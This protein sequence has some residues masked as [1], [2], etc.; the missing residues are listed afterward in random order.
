M[1]IHQQ[2]ARSFVLANYRGVTS[3]MALPKLGK[4]KKAEAAAPNIDVALTRLKAQLTIDQHA[5]DEELVRQPALVQEIGEMYA[6]AL[7]LRD[8]CKA[9]AEEVFASVD[10]ELRKDHVRNKVS[11]TE[12]SI[13]AEIAGSKEYL[14]AWAL[15]LD[16][17]NRADEINATVQAYDS[18]DRAL[19]NLVKLYVAGY[20]STAS[21]R[22]EIGKEVQADAAREAMREARKGR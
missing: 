11:F 6:R 19:G 5:L 22:G 10:S 16:H 4:E 21:G 2:L 20:W 7:A 3:P 14:D 12:A 8:T 15:Y 17:K 18:R 1:I 13:K 9:A